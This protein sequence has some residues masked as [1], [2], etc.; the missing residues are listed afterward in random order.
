MTTNMHTKGYN[1]RVTLCGENQLQNPLTGLKPDSETM[2]FQDLSVS[3]NQC[4]VMVECSSEDRTR[5]N[6]NTPLRFLNHLHHSQRSLFLSPAQTGLA[7][8]T[9]QTKYLLQVQKRKSELGVSHCMTQAD[10]AGVA[11]GE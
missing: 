9:G 8:T 3:Y 1:S 5:F 7:Y 2:F 10:I 11:R 4:G 6:L